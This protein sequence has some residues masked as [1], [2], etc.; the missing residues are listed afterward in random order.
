MKKTFKWVK[1]HK[2]IIFIALIIFILCLASFQITPSSFKDRVMG[3]ALMNNIDI[4]KIINNHYLIYCFLLPSV[5]LILAYFYNQYSSR[6][7]EKI[8]KTLNC[9]I[10][11][12]IISSILGIIDYFKNDYHS[13]FSLTL[14][15]INGLIIILILLNKLLKKSF[16]LEKFKWSCL[17][18]VPLT[19]AFL[20]ICN[21]ICPSKIGFWLGYFIMVIL[22]YMLTTS[23]KIN[24]NILSKS[25]LIF[26]V[27]PIIECLFLE[28]YN[29]L[30]QANIILQH[31]IRYLLII[32]IGCFI[33]MIIH[34]FYSLSK[35]TN[36]KFTYQKYYY[37]LIITIMSLIVFLPKMVTTV[38]VDF[39]EN[40]NEG[41]GIYEFLKYHKIPILENF[42]AHMLKQEFMGIIYGILNQDYLGAAFN[43]YSN[44][45]L[46]IFYLLV[47]FLLS[48]V[49]SKDIAFLAV[50]FFP[51]LSDSGLKYFGF[52]FLALLALLKLVKKP[53]FINYVIC[54]LTIIFLCLWR[55]DLGFSSA[56]A[57]IIILIY[58]IFKKQI[59]FR[60]LFLAFL[61]VIVPL[62][63]L[64]ISLCFIK[65]IN[66]I[67]RII[68]FLKLASSNSNW[69]Y[70]SI[71]SPKLLAYS[72]LYIFI[73]VFVVI[74]FAHTFYKNYKSKTIKTLDIITLFLGLFYLS[75]LSRGLVRHSLV[76]EKIN[77]IMGVVT[78][79]I[80]LYFYQFK[81]KISTFWF[82]YLI[83]IIISNLLISP[84][85]A[86]YSNLFNN[87]INKYQSFKI[88]NEKYFEKVNR[89]VFSKEID[90]SCK[91]L[92]NILNKLLNK[93]ETYLDLSNQTLLYAILDYPKPVYVNQ[94][95]GLLSGEYTMQQFLKE[96]A[97][98]QIPVV[99]KAN[100][101][102]HS[103]SLDGLVN[104][105]RYYLISEYVYQNY[106]PVLEVNNYEIWL[107]KNLTSR[108]DNLD[109]IE[110]YSIKRLDKTE[111]FEPETTINLGY[112]PY[113]WGKFDNKNKI[114]KTKGQSLNLKS[115]TEILINQ[116]QINKDNGNY[117]ELELE[118][119][120][121]T[122]IT[123]KLMN[124]DN[125]LKTIKLNVLSGK[126]L[127]KIRVSSF[128]EW[129]NY[130]I[131][132]LKINIPNS[133]INKIMIT[134]GDILEY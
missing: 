103:N 22:A 16:D 63:L 101:Q 60:Q 1:E 53:Q 62:I 90:D 26:L 41:L 120:K 40:A 133:Q 92:K 57:S 61:L 76:E 97:N 80:P 18:S 71:G 47:Y 33:L 81:N 118:S 38:N 126:H 116:S 95:P 72:I 34:Y 129:Y 83:V 121:D 43:I 128:Y 29:I 86:N 100:Q 130:N 45:E 48:K 3:Q 10:V 132:E 85:T 65:N 94:S 69:A 8:L 15:I 125:N 49:F 39:F 79:Y 108:L 54:W 89:V 102:K 91:E 35:K 46:V 117:L 131:N 11:F 66:P 13:L 6:L 44:F 88:Q 25:Y 28:T 50:L 82:S 42:D 122:K 75:N 27:A 20:L 77:V 114:K 110:N 56:I 111:Y 36:Q 113:V 68:E 7:N 5:V 123:I 19:F 93:G 115:D 112:L 4:N 87:A 32:Y 105:Y 37:P 9:L 70:K 98:Y 31:K 99:L 21:I 104:N 134:P 119:N 51:L 109:I 17:A 78:I 107:D 23:K 127:Y 106:E 12:D 73:P 30:N 64:Y 74:S 14:I 24:F 59:N 58:L 55:L 84:T 96:Q 67:T 2:I 124:D 52:C